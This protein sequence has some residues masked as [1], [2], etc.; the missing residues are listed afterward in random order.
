MER[1]KPIEKPEGEDGSIY[2][3]EDVDKVMAAL[4]EYCNHSREE[5]KNNLEFCASQYI[6]M[7]YNDETY[8]SGE[9]PASEEERLWVSIH[10][11]SEKLV[12]KLWALPLDCQP[13]DMGVLHE[14]QTRFSKRS[15]QLSKEASDHIKPKGGNVRDRKKHLFMVSRAE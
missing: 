14:L 13:E 4:G 5:I 2:T 7:H 9:M 11:S 15:L 10:K 3:E 12:S 1:N 6:D 8:M